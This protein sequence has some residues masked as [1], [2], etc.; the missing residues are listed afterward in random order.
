LIHCN[1][2][3]LVFI[4]FV[5]FVLPS[6]SAEAASE[7]TIPFDEETF[8]VE[9]LWNKVVANK[10][11]DRPK[12]ALVLGGGG[13]RGFAHIGVLRALISEEIP[14]DLVIGVSVGAIVGA[15]YCSG[16]EIE[17]LENLTDKIGWNKIA[18]INLFSLVSMFLNDKLLSNKNLE[19]FINKNTNYSGFEKLKIP[20]ICTATDLH[21]GERILL[22]EGDVGFAARASS[23]IPGIF[24]PVEYRQRYLIDGGI[25]GNLPTDVAKV[26]GADI[27]IAVSAAADITKNNP[28]NSFNV[29]IQSIYIQGRILDNDSMELADVLIQPPVGELSITDFKK[30]QSAIDR[31]FLS[32]R[33]SLKNIKIAIINKMTENS[34]LE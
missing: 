26:F 34:F 25:S 8:F 7:D 31:G 22:R 2:I 11:K 12:T 5:F 20:L 1:K 33:A 3:C 28:E 27:I 29:L 32:G 18:N 19:K 17:K 21:T 9:A 14:I 6:Y 15:F 10:K 4:F 24:Q 16:V 30:S 23:A 13:A